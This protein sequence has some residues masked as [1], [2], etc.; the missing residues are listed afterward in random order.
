MM[1]PNVLAY[2]YD[3][4]ASTVRRESFNNPITESAIIP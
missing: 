3:V 2:L 4:G 1:L